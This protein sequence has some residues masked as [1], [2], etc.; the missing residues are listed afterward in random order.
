MNGA[1]DTL[2]SQAY[3]DK[4]YYLCGCYLN[5]GRILQALIFIPEMILLCFT[6][7]I[8]IYL[9]QDEQTSEVAQNYIL[10][11]LPGMFAMTQFET[12]RRY[13]QGMTIFVFTMY[14]QCISLVFHLIWSY[15]LVHTAGLGIYGVSIATCITYWTDLIAVCLIISY[16]GDVVPKESWHFF[17]ADSFTGLFEYLE[18]GIPSALILS[19]EW[20]SFEIL[21]LFAGLLS[22]EELAANIVLLN[23]CILLFQVPEGV[24][25]AMSNLVGNSLGEGNTQ[26]AKKYI[27]A[28]LA[29]MFA[30]TI[31]LI[32]SLYNF[33]YYISM[34]FTDEKN[35]IE[36]I[37][38]VIP[39][40]TVWVFFDY[41]QCVECGSLRAM[42]YQLYGSAASLIGYW[43]LNLPLAYLFAFTFDMRLKGIWIGVQA[44]T[45][46]TC[47]SYTIMIFKTDWNKLAQ[48]INDRI[49]DDK[50]ELAAQL[51]N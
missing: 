46:F 21:S 39:V 16:K 48:D 33:R 8:L 30:A 10:P 40:F 29:V 5:R 14:V 50:K 37:A 7:P 32:V 15:L 24:G 47:V 20:W 38:N 23:L 42:G 44:G 3:G 45:V 34:I 26:K 13:L 9:G 28:S 43:V 17:N 18:Y 25:F 36:L 22:V 35:V 41:A 6:K 51:L 19:L 49:E 11:L 31:V 2:V 4:E 1:M 12:I 27:K